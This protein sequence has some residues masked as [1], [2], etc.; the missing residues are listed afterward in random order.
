[1]RIPRL[2]TVVLAGVAIVATVVLLFALFVVLALTQPQLL[3]DTV[4]RPK[5][6]PPTA[7]YVAIGDSYTSAPELERQ[8]AITTPQGCG[9][10]DSNYPHGVAKALGEQSFTDVSCS[11][12][13]AG[14]VAEPHLAGI[15]GAA[16][17]GEALSAQTELVTVSLGGND[18][19]ILPLL[20]ECVGEEGKP[21]DCRQQFIRDGSDKLMDSVRAIEPELDAMLDEVHQ[22]APN[23]RVLV[24]G[25]PQIFPGDGSSCP[26]EMLV[27]GGDLR[28]FDR[29]ERL[30]NDLIREAAVSHGDEYVD[31][32]TPTKGRHSCSGKDV[33]WVESMVPVAPVVT[34]HTN[35]RGQRGIEKA[36]LAAIERGR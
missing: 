6:H 28:Y 3:L 10:S 13:L 29:A 30:M 20:F 14:S 4:L 15:N 26:G 34:L 36:V 19:E 11:G 22:R 33:R 24:L 17:Q 2:K 18:A 31:T 27:T 35:E 25:Y 12:A 16:P 21:S 9:Q 23:A 1:M 5:I 8:I 32:Y 7:R